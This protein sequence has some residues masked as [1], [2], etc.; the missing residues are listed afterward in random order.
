MNHSQDEKKAERAVPALTYV[1]TN[2]SPELRSFLDGNPQGVA[3]IV[4]MK[5]ERV[6]GFNNSMKPERVHGF[7][8][9]E[10]E[11]QHASKPKDTFRQ[12]FRAGSWYFAA[13]LIDR[14][15][16]VATSE[17]SGFHVRPALVEVTFELD[18]KAYR[19]I[20]QIAAAFE[21]AYRGL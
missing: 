5:P 18:A 11:A 21:N 8:E 16:E 14:L 6:H 13:D 19:N 20:G 3:I 12:E 7:S 2:L 9:E 1:P 15:A 4:Y 17:C 10:L